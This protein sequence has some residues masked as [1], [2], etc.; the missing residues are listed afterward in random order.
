MPRVLR[1]SLLGLLALLLAL[2]LAIG[3]PVLV[4][5]A[6][7][8]TESGSRWAVQAGS[9]LVPGLA[10]TGV[11]GSLL[12]GLRLSDVSYRE[13]P[14]SDAPQGAV[15]QGAVPQPQPLQAHL[16][17]LTVRWLPLGLLQGRLRLRAVEARG[18][19]LELPPPALPQAPPA[20]P[21][22]PTDTYPVRL[23]PRIAMPLA[24]ELDQLLLEQVSVSQGQAH[25]Q[26][27]RL[28]LSGRLGRAGLK[29]DTLR[30]EGE[31]VT[32]ALSGR[33][34][35]AYPYA[36]ALQADWHVARADL[37]EAAGQGE[38][39]GDVERLTL[40]QHLRLPYVAE[41][42]GSLTPD[43]VAGH[44]RFDL[45]GEWAELALP[46]GSDTLHSR[47]GRLSLKGGL[48]AI[49]LALS[50][51]LQHPAIS[52]AVSVKI[53]G[54]L[55][56]DLKDGHHRFDLTGE[57][58]DLALPVGTDTLHSRQGKLTLRGEPGAYQLAL[59]TQVQ[60]PAGSE[61]IAVDIAGH[62]DLGQ[63]NVERGRLRALGGEAQFSGRLG[64]APTLAWEATLTASAIDPGRQ[65]PEW[66]G[67][68]ALDAAVRGA[69]VADALQLE[70]ELRQLRGTLR[71]YPVAGQGQMSLVGDKLA[72]HGLRLRSG[73]NRVQLDG[74]LYPDLH[75][76]FEIDA[77]DLQQ[78]APRLAGSLQGKGS[79]QGRPA[80]PAVQLSLHGRRLAVAGV[81]A[82]VLE[83]EAAIDPADAQ[84]SHW[85]LQ[86]K[87]I[88]GQ[89]RQLASVSITGTGNAGQHRFSARASGADAELDL[90]AAGR[91]AGQQWQGEIASLQLGNTLLGRWQLEQPFGL[92]AGATAVNVAPLCLAQAQAPAQA[93]ARA[94]VSGL[95]LKDGR[96]QSAGELSGLSLALLRP[97]LSEEAEVDGVVSGSF[98]VEGRLE[99]LQA[100]AALSLSPG[101]LRYT[102]ASGP[103]FVADHHDGQLTLSYRDDALQA[104][105]G[106]GLGETGRL[107]GKAG[108]GAE[109]GGQRALTGELD[110][111]LADPRPLGAV[112]PQLSDWSGP[113]RLHSLLGG[114]LQRPTVKLDGDWRD[115][116]VRVPDLGITLSAIQLGVAGDGDRL[117]LQGQAVS[118]QGKVNLTGEAVLDGAAGWPVHL[119]IVGEDVQVARRSDLELSVTP[120]L[121][122]ALTRQAISVAG[123][124]AVPY[125]RIV[126]ADIPRGVVRASPDEII[127]GDAATPAAPSRR[128]GPDIRAQLRLSLGKDVRLKAYG[129]DTRLSGELDL[130]QAPDAPV[131]AIGQLNLLEGRYKAYG[132]DLSIEQGRLV[133][134]GPL[135]SADVNVRAVRKLETVT[136][137]ILLSGPL[138][139]PTTQ[140]FSEP[141]MDEANILSYLLTGGPLGE[142]RGVNAAVLAQA[143]VSLGL[144]K[145]SSIMAQL[146][147]TLGID[148]LSVTGGENGLGSSAMAIGKR[149]SPD[150]YVRYLYGLF[151]GAATIQL[152]YN[153]NKHLRLE[154]GAGQQRS[155]DLLYEIER[156]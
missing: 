87:G 53:A 74:A 152:R 79:L 134:A 102:P 64:W 51:Q 22:Q 50:T 119:H 117:S 69:W 52:E 136:A 122:V 54:S 2:S 138:T 107:Q 124:L 34:A 110:F 59:T 123:K 91:L 30:L 125:A 3:L 58:A 63:L 144:D 9:R 1:R 21:G 40:K 36:M 96:L 81:R 39:S 93:P 104:R 15:P 131:E 48:D 95:Q 101:T 148:E 32:L 120:D 85:S 133:F 19:R 89:G 73:D 94:C 70:V 28:A 68:L 130:H 7:A 77:A 78:L 45:T 97:W 100:E 33:V 66:P 20:A 72:V 16:D 71:D 140:L 137:G 128:Q 98:H 80:D 27:D 38:L 143:A 129:L 135:T 142:G 126:L 67:A 146:A 18:L 115:G 106:L 139:A 147:G 46:V 43:L 55:V 12:S 151:D 61:A 99:Q 141:S 103:E 17:T 145:S 86:G 29:L 109:A 88:E 11:Q 76:S 114:T 25:W 5:I 24:L 113:M 154:G 49:E 31:G 84:R 82:D 60:A 23:P 156:K 10:V 132:Q 153:L 92:Q 75:T 8:A 105:L 26:L 41:I 116:Q 4:L 13:A 56:P 127:V 121:E 44:H 83:L 90:T 35:G 108:L 149:L 57:W 62:G 47:Q 65:W 6:G 112:V 118:G 42:A 155:L 37:P 111:A 14:G 150:L